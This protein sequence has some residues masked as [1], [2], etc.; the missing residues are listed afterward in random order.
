MQEANLQEASLQGTDLQEADLRGCD[1]DYSCFPL[2]CGG[3]SVKVDQRIAAQIAY[4]LCA[5]KCDDPEF[6]RMRNSI[7][8]FANQFHRVDEC[9]KL[10]EC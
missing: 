1:L 10:E 5:L 4:H 8:W 2:W 3:L 7:L 9:G 6:L